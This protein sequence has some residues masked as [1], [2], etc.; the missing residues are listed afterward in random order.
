MAYPDLGANYCTQQ[1]MPR[2]EELA[3]LRSLDQDLEITYSPANTAFG[4][5][6]TLSTLS[7]DDVFF[8]ITERASTI[9]PR[10]NIDF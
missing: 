2:I 10:N 6:R 7:T 4:I 3:L 8:T 5:K 9:K 1:F